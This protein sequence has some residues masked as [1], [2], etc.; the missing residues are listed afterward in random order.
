[1]VGNPLI[2]KQMVEHLPDAGCYAQVTILINE[3]TDGCICL[4]TG[5]PVFWLPTKMCQLLRSRKIWTPR[6]EA[7]LLIAAG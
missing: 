6:A 2:M 4:M 3:R 1:V 7:L 5:W